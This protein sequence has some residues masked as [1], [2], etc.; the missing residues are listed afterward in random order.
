MPALRGARSL[1]AVAACVLLVGGCV[2]A[3]GAEP[4]D[5]E[6]PK[7]IGIGKEPPHATMLPH[8]E[9]EWAM[10]GMRKAAPHFL[11]LGGNWKFHW[12]C[13][14]STLVKLGRRLQDSGSSVVPQ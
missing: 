9:I 10:R 5:W 3:F 13:V 12:A 8:P 6:N 4:P 2:P 7:V 14:R 11:P 1:S